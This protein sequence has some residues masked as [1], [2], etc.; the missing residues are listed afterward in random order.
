[1]NTTSSLEE[2]AKLAFL[3]CG[4]MIKQKPSAGLFAQDKPRDYLLQM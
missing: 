1:M 2:G 4:Q 3:T